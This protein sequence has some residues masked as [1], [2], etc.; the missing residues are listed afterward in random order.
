L[1]GNFA[2]NPLA[3]AFLYLVIP[4][5]LV[6]VFLT[7][8]GYVPDEGGHL[9]RIDAI[10]HG[11]FAGHREVT[12]APDGHAVE[13]AGEFGD[14]ALVGATLGW[15]PPAPAWVLPVREQFNWTPHPVFINNFQL[16]VYFPLY[17]IAPAI[18]LAAGKLLGER[19][20]EAIFLARL[21]SFCIYALL[22]LLALRTAR[23]GRGILFFVLAMPMT[24]YLAAST[25]PDGGLIPTTCLGFALLTAGRR[26]AAALC[27]A[28]LILVK[29]P[30]ALMALALLLPLPRVEDLWPE[31]KA[32]LKHTGLAVITVLPS[33]IWFIW[34]TAY[35]SVP[36]VRPAYLPGPMWPGSPA[37]V[38]DAVAPAAQL[39]SVIAHPLGFL[40]IVVTE[41]LGSWN[42]LAREMI[43]MLGCQN[44]AIP[45]WLYV[46]WGLA[47]A[48]SLWSEIPVGPAGR[49]TVLTAICALFVCGLTVL[50]I[51]LGEYLNWTNV[52]T[53]SI[54]GLEGRYLLPVLPLL[55]FLIPRWT[56]P[57]ALPFF[58]AGIWLPVLAALIDLAILPG[59]FA[60]HG[61]IA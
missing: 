49:I 21:C 13:A 24:V 35:V 23:F 25:N 44:V 42:L 2:G 26:R 18:G 8:P 41:T 53:P 48:A 14:P 22:G 11:E 7:P 34:T 46:L 39:Q 6:F 3:R 51:W 61:Q 1:R 55:I 47:G 9:V 60:H 5:G 10:L 54:Q 56:F 4:L 43:G 45:N 40:G 32:L 30:Y 27:L 58:R 36:V 38:F 52:G 29:P 15:P 59:W 28:A 31:R 19:P 17:Y 16:S 50:L 12:I 20:Y 37:T 57:G 33:V